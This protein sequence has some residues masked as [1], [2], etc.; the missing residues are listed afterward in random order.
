MSCSVRPCLPP[1]ENIKFS[2]CLS[3]G[4]NPE[5]TN[6]IFNKIFI[7]NYSELAFKEFQSD[8]ELRV[9]VMKNIIASFN[10]QIHHEIIKENI[11]FAVRMI[12]EYSLSISD[13]EDRL[14][15]IKRSIGELHFP[16]D[17]NQTCHWF[18]E[19]RRRL[20][21]EG[22]L[23][24]Q[25]QIAIALSK[26]IDK[27]NVFISKISPAKIKRERTEAVRLIVSMQLLPKPVNLG[28]STVVFYSGE[29]RRC[30]RSICHRDKELKRVCEKANGENL[31][32]LLSK[33][34]QEDHQRD[35]C[36]QALY[37]FVSILNHLSLFVNKFN[38]HIYIMV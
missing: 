8:P 4:P 36:D 21:V 11:G 1:L 37:Q 15:V 16:N 19:C 9:N 17:H 31:V 12:G 34:L 7:E 32:N 33:K 24:L 29:I 30:M 20:L 14:S 3:L 28:P 38:L 35:L 10:C 23:K 6:E 26:L 25:S 27:L 13:I 5:K 2:G 22:D 18:E